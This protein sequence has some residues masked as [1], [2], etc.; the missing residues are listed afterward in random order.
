MRV[1][2]RR[3]QEEEEESV[4]VSMTDMTVSFL[5]IVMVLLAFFASQLHDPDKVPK[6][7]FDVVAQE[8]DALRAENVYL[9]EKLQKLEAELRK[10]KP[11]QPMEAYLAEVAKQRKRILE[12]LQAKLRMDFPDLQVVISEEMDA[13]RFKGD[14]LFQSGS[15]ELQPDKRRIVQSIAAR[16]GE[17]LP[18]YTVG[19]LSSWNDGCNQTGAAIEA[20]QIEGHTDSDGAEIN[21]VTLS[22]SRADQT[23]FA[24]LEREP[25]LVEHRNN[26]GQPVLG[27]A[28]YGRMRPV[29][30]NGTKEGRA[31]NRRIDLRI[32]MYTPRSLEDIKR[33]RED[34]HKGLAEVIVR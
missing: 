11:D 34:L 17:I 4:F 30:D 20:V 33:V 15:S 8:R 5:F 28:G 22:T 29:A 23:L 14:G 6:R 31:T 32:I 26:R 7:D 13:L 27:V 12:N 25:M 10:L 2:L 21:N 18:C 3:H 24:M 1:V 9:R 19:R 16:L